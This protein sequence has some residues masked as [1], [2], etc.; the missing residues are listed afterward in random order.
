[1]PYLQ[2]P[3]FEARNPKQIQIANFKFSK[4]QMPP[5]PNSKSQAPKLKQAPK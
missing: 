1:V 2:N 4:R 5:D 3:K